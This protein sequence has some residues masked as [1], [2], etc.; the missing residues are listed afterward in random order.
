VSGKKNDSDISKAE[1]PTLLHP[2]MEHSKKKAAESCSRINK[3][4]F[5][6]IIK[7][8]DGINLIS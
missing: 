8:T 7:K 3:K 2:F 6:L 4:C 1:H 5:I